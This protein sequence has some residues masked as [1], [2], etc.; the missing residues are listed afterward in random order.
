VT[1]TKR[2]LERLKTIQAVID[3]EIKPGRATGRPMVSHCPSPPCWK[4]HTQGDY[5]V[6]ASPYFGTDL[7]PD[8]NW[9]SSVQYQLTEA[10]NTIQRDFCR[11]VGAIMSRRNRLALAYYLVDRLVIGF[12]PT[13]SAGTS[14][15]LIELSV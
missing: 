4:L 8:Y 3:R 14:V 1:L 13:R 5:F 2:A 6:S 12:W 10:P 9:Q 7:E 11:L 15:A